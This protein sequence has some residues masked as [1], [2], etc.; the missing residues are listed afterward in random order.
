MR[1]EAVLFDVGNTLLRVPHDPHRLAVA[2]ASHLGSIPF[3]SYKAN[4]NRAREEWWRAIGDHAAQD[5][6]ETWI[7][8]NHRALELLGFA[9]NISLAAR[10]IEESFLLDGWEVYSEAVEVLEHIS[11]RGIR[12]GV[13]SNWPP[14][15][16]ATLEAAGLKR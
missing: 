14:T 10:L 4:L 9:G 1:F 8:H 3:E 2:A 16:E 11:H 7:A 15:L 13:I 12:M 5:L 6:P